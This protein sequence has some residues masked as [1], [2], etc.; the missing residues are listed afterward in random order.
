MHNDGNEFLRLVGVRPYNPRKSKVA[1]YA[2]NNNYSA[3]EKVTKKKR[4]ADFRS[5]VFH[6]NISIWIET[7]RTRVHVFR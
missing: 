7:H 6:E 5:L 1:F 4:G 2:R 3:K